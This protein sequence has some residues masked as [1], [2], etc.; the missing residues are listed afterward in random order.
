VLPTVAD[1]PVTEV[2]LKV[3]DITVTEGTIIRFVETAVAPVVPVTFTVVLLD[4]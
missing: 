4:S 3:T 1:P 2:G